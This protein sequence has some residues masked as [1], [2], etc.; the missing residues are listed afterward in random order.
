MTTPTKR[1]E[2]ILDLPPGWQN[3]DKLS[4]IAYPAHFAPMNVASGYKLVRIFVDL[5]HVPLHGEIETVTAAVVV[6]DQGRHCPVPYCN[7]SG[8]YPVADSDGNCYSNPCKWCH[9]TP[10]SRFNRAQAATAP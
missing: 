3:T 8:V 9:D 7:D 4:E 6:E 5:P 1:V 10:D 2:F